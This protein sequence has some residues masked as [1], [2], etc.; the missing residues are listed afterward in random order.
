MSVSENSAIVRFFIALWS[1]L[2][3]S[4]PHSGPGRLFGC[5][6]RAI[7]GQVERS[8]VCRFLWREGALP[9]GWPY[10]LS[11]RFFTALINLPCAL[12]KWIY[13]V[14]RRLWDGSLAF[15][16][17]SALGGASFA[18]LGL[19]MLVM[20]CA[21]HSLWNNLYGLMGA[22]GLTVLFVLGSA[23]RPRLR[24]ELDRLGPYMLLYMGLVVYALAGSMS[25]SMS[26]RFFA[27]HLTG[28]LIVLLVVS[29]VRK[30]EQLQLM[31]VLAVVGITVAALYGCYQ[32]YI[33]VE[34]VPSQQD[35]IVNEGMPGRVYSFFDN[36]NNFAE[37]L[38]M[39]IPLD[40]ALLLNAKGWRGRLLSLFSLGVCVAAIGLTYGRASWLGLALAVVVFLGLM[41]WRFIPLFIVLGICAIPLL[42]ETIYNRIL[43]IGNTQDSSTRYRFSIFEATGEL[44]KTYWLRG[45][46]LGSD[47]MQAVFRAQYPPMSNG[48]YP[49][50]THNNYLQMWV[51]AGIVGAVAYVALLL[52]QLKAGVKSVLACT[53]RRV[54]SML[55]AA[56]AGLCGIMLISVAEYTW[57]YPRNMFVFW[58]LMGLIGAGVKLTRG[59]A[60]QKQ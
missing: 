14:G 34:V 46:G 35:M 49:I 9:R 18:F 30:Y 58:F 13:K 4:W 59:G 60:E 17:I 47:V 7:R 10:S 42:P 53:D 36:P 11:C 3:D 12:A 51:E 20:L 40:V 41:N 43:T 39:L 16:V 44:L 2:S 33:G 27:F 29:C 26:V 37:L 5:I 52:H 38:A 48:A 56:L 28:F 50:H 21:P 31:A 23:A 55:S 57:F 45:V 8:A 1:T 54:K 6:G 22:L 32:G 25:T 19:F 15:Q 24:L